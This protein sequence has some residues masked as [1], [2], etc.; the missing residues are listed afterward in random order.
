MS[1]SILGKR[2]R[3]PEAS[4]LA[5][6]F[7][8]DDSLVVRDNTEYLAR[9][10]KLSLFTR[11]TQLGKSTFFSLAELVYSK[12]KEAP[13][14]VAKNIDKKERN[15]GYVVTFDLLSVAVV[16]MPTDWK[17]DLLAT[18][19][20]F[21]KKVKQT[22]E[23][24]I[25]NNKELQEHFIAPEMSEQLAGD[26][27]EALGQA[28][29]DTKVNE[30][31]LVVLVDEFDR[32]LR[33]TLFHLFSQFEKQDVI[34]HCPNY[35]SFFA[36]C[37]SVGQMDGRN[38]VWV[39]GVLPIALD[40]ISDFQP[41]N[42]TFSADMLDAVGLRDLDVD[43]MLSRVHATVP[44]TNDDEMQRVRNAI[45][46]HANHLQFLSGPPLYHTRMVNEI[47]NIVTDVDSRKIWLRNLSRL[48]NGVT[49]ER[50]PSV[51]YNLLQKSAPCRNVAKDLV[52]NKGIP[53]NLNVHL[54]LPDVCQAGIVKDDYLTLLVHLGVA[55]VK[56]RTV[57]DMDGSHLFC[58]TSHYFRSE[59]LKA[60]LNVTLTPMFSCES[61][62]KIYEN[63][64]LLQEFLETLPSKGLA[65]MIAWA[66]SSRT[67]RILE[68]QFQG[69][70]LGELHDLIMSDDDTSITPTQEDRISSDMRTDVQLKGHQTIL[71]LE[72]KQQQSSP[73]KAAMIKFH[74][75]L[76]K[77]VNKVSNEQPQCLVAGFVV[78]MYAT[79]TKFRVEPFQNL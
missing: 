16:S 72:L 59:Y 66:K 37:K 43:N 9:M 41:S 32:P 69:V 57:A 7:E 44:F 34:A 58:A 54:N 6:I 23:R 5:E 53:G 36:T 24:F 65:K 79:G 21:F 30:D 4:E 75:Q 46:H 8:R 31:F 50:A 2:P 39:T 29:S 15:A 77:Y 20:S 28:V 11:P 40:L 56:E 51:I 38:K 71:I 10:N 19:R 76:R 70:L 18:D 68:L 47:L 22:V 67:N 48:P 60:M 17:D 35:V 3:F 33:Y 14:E 42:K 52:A 26:Y 27:L 1:T 64:P 74:S 73:T 13:S 55:Y 61:V 78:V 12:T 62:D 63:Q 49:R 45:R 25:R